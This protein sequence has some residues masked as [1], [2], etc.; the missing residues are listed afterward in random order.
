MDGRYSWQQPGR[1]GSSES[2]LSPLKSEQPEVRGITKPATKS[3]G[4]K[5]DGEKRKKTPKGESELSFDAGG[6]SDMLQLA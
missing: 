5:V 1:S 4:R 6:G 3:K 2:S